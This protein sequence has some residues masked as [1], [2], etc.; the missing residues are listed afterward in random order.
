MPSEKMNDLAL[1]LLMTSLQHR[2]AADVMRSQIE[3]GEVLADQLDALAQRLD[4]ISAGIV[5]GLYD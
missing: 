3:N 4:D 5:E 1:L 2:Q